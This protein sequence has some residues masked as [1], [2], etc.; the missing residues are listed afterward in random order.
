LLLSE[1][2]PI[3][4][5]SKA[6]VTS[7]AARRVDIDATGFAV[8]DMGDADSPECPYASAARTFRRFAGLAA[9]PVVLV[10]ERVRAAR[11]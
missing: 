1:Y 2:R 3:A 6:R 8:A 9:S 11:R 10:A 4:Y 5:S 7:G